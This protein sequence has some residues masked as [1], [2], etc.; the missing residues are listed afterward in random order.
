MINQETK[1]IKFHQ[2]QC[3]DRAV[4]VSAVMQEQVSQIQLMRRIFGEGYLTRKFGL[5]LRYRKSVL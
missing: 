1:Y 4:E 5:D 3:T 2:N